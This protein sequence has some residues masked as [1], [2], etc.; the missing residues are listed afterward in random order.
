MG[1]IPTNKDFSRNNDIDV[2]VIGA[3]Y[4]GLSAAIELK[5]KGCNVHLIEREQKLQILGDIITI[6]ANASLVMEKWGDV[7]EQMAA[8]S[9]TPGIVTFRSDKGEVLLKQD[10]KDKYNGHYNLYT[11]RARSQGLI[12]EYAVKIGVKFTWGARI[13]DFW[14]EGD[15][16]GIYLN[17]ELLKADFVVGADGV[18]SRARQYVT[19]NTQMAQRSG[20]AV[21]RAYFSRDYLKKDPLTHDLAYSENDQLIIWIGLD[22]HAIIIVNA[23]LGYISAYLTHKDTYTVEESWTYPGT[24]KDML[25]VVKD[26]DPVLE[27]AIRQIPEEVICDFKLLWRDPID[28]WVSDAGRIV[29]IGDAA[30]PHLPTSGSGGGMGVEDGATLASLVDRAGRSDIPSALRAFQKL[31]YDRTS[32]TQRMGW[33][34]RHKWHQTDWERVKRE[35]DFLKIPQPDWLYSANAEQYGYEKFDEVMAHIKEGKPFRNTNV[36]DNYQPDDWNIKTMTEL[37]ASMGTDNLYKIA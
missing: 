27:A 5:R 16:A 21:Y 22:L 20:F 30:H 36:P 10:W 3:G 2:I 26:C 12:Y 6:T 18:Y 8:E 19:G 31:R 35:P 25:K 33:E 1:S 28:K 11:S 13:T 34:V 29:L 7:V 14:E 32:T 17:G 24:V 9:A 15:K 37:D 23:K 4:A